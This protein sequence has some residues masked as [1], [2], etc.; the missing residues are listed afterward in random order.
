MAS[1]AEQN[2]PPLSRPRS[3]FQKVVRELAEA[4]QKTLYHDVGS[5]E[6]E[7]RNGVRYLE[8]VFSRILRGKLKSE[9]HHG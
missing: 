6:P 2:S 3:E 9:P 1:L 4:A 7:Y 5:D 8:P